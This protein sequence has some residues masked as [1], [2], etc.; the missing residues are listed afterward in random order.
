LNVTSAKVL[1][2]AL[3]DVDIP[4]LPMWRIRSKLKKDLKLTYAK[5]HK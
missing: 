5:L 4:I 2:E 3:K 1:Q